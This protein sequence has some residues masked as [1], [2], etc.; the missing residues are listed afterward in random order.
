MGTQALRC[1]AALV[2]GQFGENAGVLG[3]GLGGVPGAEEDFPAPAGRVADG[4]AGLP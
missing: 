1:A 4:D 3:P 2:R